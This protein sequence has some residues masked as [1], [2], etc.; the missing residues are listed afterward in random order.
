MEVDL[1][2]PRNQLLVPDAKLINSVQAFRVHEKLSVLA[3]VQTLVGEIGDSGLQDGD[4]LATRLVKL[5]CVLIR[6]KADHAGEIRLITDYNVPPLLLLTSLQGDLTSRTYLV[7]NA[8]KVYR[9]L[10]LSLSNGLQ[11]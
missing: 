7:D 4:D 11:I 10:G 8:D 9:C 1:V 6:P 3:R 2:R 5:L